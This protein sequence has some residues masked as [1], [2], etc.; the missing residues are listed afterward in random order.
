MYFYNP[1]KWSFSLHP[2]GVRVHTVVM[3]LVAPVL[4][5]GLVLFLP[6]VGLY[7][8]GREVV[9]RAWHAWSSVPCS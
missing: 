2:P 1:R 9:N 5:A 8:I 4:G 6:L 3:L 7:L